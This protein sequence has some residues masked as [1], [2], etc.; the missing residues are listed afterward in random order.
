MGMK[1]K[2]VLSLHEGSVVET[3]TRTKL[4]EGITAFAA[5]FTSGLVI[6]SAVCTDKSC[7]SLN[8]NISSG[9]HV[10]PN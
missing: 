7:L 9:P 4:L 8:C 5:N 1:S 6:S 10:I 2:H 3:V